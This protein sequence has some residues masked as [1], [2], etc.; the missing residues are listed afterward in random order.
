MRKFFTA[1]FLS[2]FLFYSSNAQQLEPGMVAPAPHFD[3]WLKGETIST[4]ERGKV[5]VIDCWSTWCSPCIASMPHL[6][7]LQ[8]QY[9][10]V[11]FIALNV[12]EPDLARP[13]A[14]VKSRDTSLHFRVATDQFD[15]G[16]DQPGYMDRNYLQTTGILGIP[17]TYVINQEGKLVFIGNP[18]E[19]DVV[20]PKVID[21]TWD[22]DTYKQRSLGNLTY[23][24]LNNNF[25][26][27]E[28]EFVS[29]GDTALLYG[30]Y[31]K[32]FSLFSERRPDRVREIIWSRM[33]D[34][35]GGSLLIPQMRNYAFGIRWMRNII[36]YYYHPKDAYFTTSWLYAKA[37]D[38]KESAAIIEEY[39][40]ELQQQQDELNA[41]QK[42]LNM[43]FQKSK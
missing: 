20:L 40:K 30:F 33:A 6:S 27:E 28:K 19:L 11:I 3:E 16:K 15:K 13:K 39:K 17:A 38:K 24:Y 8:D 34:P 22:I 35:N 7:Q 10:D 32:R 29:K 43:F 9:P 41:T 4:F 36:S 14:F 23:N 18:Y 1:G 26:R 31:E 12:G 2:C 37:G 25:D 42:G 21:K 5:Y